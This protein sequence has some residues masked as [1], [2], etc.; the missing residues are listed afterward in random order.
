MPAAAQSWPSKPIRLI[1]TIAAGAVT[2]VAARSLA[3]DLGTRLGQSVI[4][5]NRPGANMIIGTQECGNAD[6]DGYTLCITS[7]DAMSYN[8]VLM[9]QLPYNADTDFK[10]V[11]NMYFVMEALL[12]SGKVEAKTAADMRRLAAASPGKFNFGTLGP[13]STIDIFRKWLNAQW[14]SDFVAV[15]YKGG[16]E[17]VNALLQGDIDI[18]RIG[19]GNIAGF[20]ED[21]RINVLAVRSPKRLRLA[22]NVPTMD[23]VGLAYPGRAWW[24]VFVPAKTSDDIVARLNREIVAIIKEPKTVDFMETQFL[25][26]STGTPGEFA[27]FLKQDRENARKLI[28]AYGTK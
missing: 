10:P 6:P 18:A 28:E 4:I 3:Q 5:V 24:G 15:P 27:A 21:K 19:L 13:G 25:E 17:V 2:D 8:P 26:I 20:L 7:S 22:P 16:N 23:E 12:A 9:S 11:T 1:V 14:K